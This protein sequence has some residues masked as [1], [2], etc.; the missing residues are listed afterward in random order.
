MS[1]KQIVETNFDEAWLCREF[2]EFDEELPNVAKAVVL[3]GI[4]WQTLDDEEIVDDDDREHKQE[5]FNSVLAI[6]RETV[7]CTS[8]MTADELDVAMTNVLTACHLVKMVNEGLVDE[9]VDGS[10]MLSDAGREYYNMLDE[11]GVFDEGTED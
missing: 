7:S 6:L 8:E 4:D 11:N 3:R 9:K 10:Y 2:E 5:V 1:E